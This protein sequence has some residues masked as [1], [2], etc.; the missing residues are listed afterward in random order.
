MSALEVSAVIYFAFNL[1][2]IELKL[3]SF[4][5]RYSAMQ[6]LYFITRRSNSLSSDTHCMTTV[7]TCSSE[8]GHRPHLQITTAGSLCL[9]VS[10]SV[11]VLTSC[12]L[13][14]LQ[15]FDIIKF[16]CSCVFNQAFKLVKLKTSVAQLHITSVRL[17][18]F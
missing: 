9:C 16:N 12:R 5:C 7:N 11:T 18:V 8:A 2:L 4:S 14:L 6:L 1:P 10:V 15:S 17:E 3:T 13:Y